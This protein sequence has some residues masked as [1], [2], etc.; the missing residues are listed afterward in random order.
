MLPAISLCSQLRND[1]KSANAI[2]DYDDLLLMDTA[3]IFLD[4]DRFKA[5]ND[6]LGHG[7][8]D[9]LLIKVAHRLRRN[10]RSSDIVARRGGDEFV[11]VL[12]EV[13]DVTAAARLAGKIRQALA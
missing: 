5:V 6:T 4:L 13:E 11:I 1:L 7:V 9:G 10:V 8:G 12:T 3:V 2:T